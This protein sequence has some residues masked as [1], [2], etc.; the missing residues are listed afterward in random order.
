MLTNK[1]LKD[2]WS[3]LTKYNVT[4]AQVAEKLGVSETAVYNILNGKTKKAHEAIKLMIEMRKT[5][6]EQWNA[7]L[8]DNK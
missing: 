3:D 8:N 2:L 6:K 4:I 1:Q 7:Y 5:A